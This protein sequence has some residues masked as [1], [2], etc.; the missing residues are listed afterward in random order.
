M[1]RIYASGA[2][3]LFISLV[4]HPA[5]LCAQQPTATRP[6]QPTATRPDQTPPTAAPTPPVDNGGVR[7]VEK[8]PAGFGQ[9][10]GNAQSLTID[11]AI[12]LALQQASVYQQSQFD[13]RIAA[14][15]VKQAR[16]GFFPQFTVPLTYFGTTPSRYRIEE[17]PPT[18]SYVSSSAINETIALLQATGE[19]DLS[20]RLRSQ[21]RRSRYLLEAAR[22]G[23]LIARR[24][25]A[26]NTVDSYYALVLARQKRRLAEETL[27]LAEGFVKVVEGRM[28][29]GE[30]E[31]EGADILRAR[32]QAA[33]RRD[34]LEQA[35]AGEAAAMDVLRVL[36]GTNF[37][38]LIGVSGIS[39]DLP[40]ASDFMSYTE[41]VLKTRPEL[42][43]IDAQ[44]RAAQAEAQTA[45]RERLP[46]I[47]YTVNGGFDAADFRPLSRYSGGS[48]TVTLSIPIFDFGASRSRETQA[49]LRAQALDAQREVT[50]RLLQQEFYTA[51]ATALAALAR[52]RETELGVDQAQ[53][54]LM[55]VF[56]RYRAKKA[57]IID[58][59]DAQS[60]YAEARLA[61]SQAIIDYRTA[62]FRLEQ[63]LGK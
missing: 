28:Q 47:G 53:K 25:L 49:R 16:A 35:R 10:Q 14:E 48:A 15:D 4:W 32:A 57:E 39:D 21:L 27:S 13:E 52:I 6:Q 3:L 40:T 56:A 59:V 46:Q 58:V 5:Q 44:K 18:F 43:Q 17:E 37:S 34:E 31:S 55:L 36:V 19:L 24:A 33:S 38:T 26:L 60:A 50:T 2:L 29:R 8:P 45:R 51:R 62:R 63:N 22:A 41:E 42:A 30:D 20:G 1:K 7:R 12:S 11:E 9:P 23:T 61:Y 54:N